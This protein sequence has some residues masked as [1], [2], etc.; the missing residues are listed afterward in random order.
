MSDLTIEHHLRTLMGPDASID[1][2][3]T[4]IPVIAPRTTEACALVLRTANAE[5]WKVRITGHGTWSPVDAPAH[6]TLSSAGLTNIED[7]Q[8]TDLVATVQ[9]GVDRDA[10]R[11][12]LADD[13]A[14]WPVD[15]P[16]GHRSLGSIIATAT[17]GPLRSGF[18]GVRD[19]VLGLTVVTA[20]GRIVHAGGRVVKNVAGFDL[21]KLATGSFGAF[22]FIAAAHL[23]LRAIP[24]ADVTLTTE[25]DRDDLIQDARAILGTGLIPP[26]VEIVSPAV[27]GSD[28]WTLAVRLLGADPQ[29]EA[30]RNLVKGVGHRTWTEQ[31][32]PDAAALWRQTLSRVV[33]GPITV[34][35]GTVVTALDRAVDLIAHHLD[36]DIVTVSVACGVVRWTGTAEADRCRLLRHAAAQVEMPVTVERAPWNARSALGHFGAYREGVGRL[37]GSL[38]HTFDPA[39]TLVVPLGTDDET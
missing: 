5:R 4:G 24:R 20:D 15:P 34:R 22:G 23:R 30:D 35:L 32:A 27:L 17:A 29:V 7:V 8:G 16:G 28:R 18:G 33:A 25:G 19:H 3:P 39:G 11:V 12:A 13:G 2:D 9:A 21:T 1:T 38:R 6:L 14:W 31:A 10:L 36:D 37:M 26:A